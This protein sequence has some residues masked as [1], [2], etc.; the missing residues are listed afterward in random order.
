MQIKLLASQIA[1]WIFLIRL[2]GDINILVPM[3]EP[4]SRIFFTFHGFWAQ[5]SLL[6]EAFPWNRIRRVRAHLSGAL[7]AET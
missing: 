4:D 6:G 1:D 5:A 7:C 2:T 3:Q